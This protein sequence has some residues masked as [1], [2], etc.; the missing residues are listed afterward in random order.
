MKLL[1][2]MNLSPLLA[3]ILNQAGHETI[4]WFSIGNPGADDLEII[5]YAHENGFVIITHDLDFG[6]ILAV[7]HAKFPSILQIRTQNVSPD[8]ISNILLKTLQR[9][10]SQLEQG[11]LISIDEARSRA[12]ILPVK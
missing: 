3:E 5:N 1:I 11:A 2:D 4:H 6:D 12:R 7:T 10:K 8:H 9:F